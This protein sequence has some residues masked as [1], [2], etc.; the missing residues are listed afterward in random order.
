MVEKTRGA[1]AT[2]ILGDI[3]NLAYKYRLENG[4]INGIQNSDVNIGTAA[5]LHITLLT[6]Y[7]QGGSLTVLSRF[8]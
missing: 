6:G 5:D 7:T 3:R 8:I 1:E 4:T 2:V